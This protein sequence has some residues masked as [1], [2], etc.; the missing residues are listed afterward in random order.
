MF[1]WFKK[2]KSGKASV[3]KLDFEEYKGFQIAATPI[4]EGGQFR[5]SGVIELAAEGETTKQHRFV[6]ADLI[7]NEEEAVRITQLKARMMV[8]QMGER[9]FEE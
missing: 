4:N 7:P 5:V 2:D 8:D 9:L 6:R 1:G 3:P